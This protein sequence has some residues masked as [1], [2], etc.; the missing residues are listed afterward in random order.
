VFNKDKRPLP[1]ILGLST[2]IILLDHSLL[3]QPI[4]CRF[5]GPNQTK[6]LKTAINYD[7]IVIIPPETTVL[8]LA[9]TMA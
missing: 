5:I 2:K 8:K 1:P 6:P 9:E 3:D 4:L 7:K